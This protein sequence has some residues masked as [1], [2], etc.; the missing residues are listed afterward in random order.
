MTALVDL[1]H[2]VQREWQ[3][4]RLHLHLF[5]HKY[6]AISL[7]S[8]RFSRADYF[9]RDRIGVE[10]RAAR[11]SAPCL[12]KWHYWMPL[13]I[14]LWNNSP[15]SHTNHISFCTILIHFLLALM[16]RTVLT[17]LCARRMLQNIGRCSK[18][19]TRHYNGQERASHNLICI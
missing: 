18:S 7:Q 1:C 10:W 13:P 8:G 14:A 9:A 16:P 17:F 5:A 3:S 11:Q 4:S 6:S 19:R 12:Y 15:Q 2:F